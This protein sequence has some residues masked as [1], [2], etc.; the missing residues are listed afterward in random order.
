VTNIVIALDEEF[1]S[2]VAYFYITLNTPCFIPKLSNL[3]VILVHIYMYYRF[4]F[5][6]MVYLGALSAKL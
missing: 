5:V 6:A 1:K 4:T 2:P 3:A